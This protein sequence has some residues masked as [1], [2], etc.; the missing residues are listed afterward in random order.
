MISVALEIISALIFIHVTAFAYA[1]ALIYLLAISA[2]ST[3]FFALADG[4]LPKRIFIFMTYAIYF[5]LSAGLGM[6]IPETFFSDNWIAMQINRILLST[7]GI[8]F[9]RS[10]TLNRALELIGEIRKGW[11]YLA[12]FSTISILVS[13][14]ICIALFVDENN[15]LF[16]PFAAFSIVLFS[17]YVIIFRM[18]GFMAKE[19]E[20]NL[21][22]MQ[23]M[24]LSIRSFVSRQDVAVTQVYLSLS[25]AMIFPRILDYRNQIQYRYSETC[26]R[27]RLMPH[28][29][30]TM[31]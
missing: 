8:V 27:M 22:N 3:V 25:R 13:S 15:R 26:W 29:N 30:A 14:I 28:Q 21:I 24:T 1:V 18:I 19:N 5:I 9:I 4:P 12:V 20:I 10:S 2:Y 31:A 11:W 17:S 16:I 7:L 6:Y 23:A